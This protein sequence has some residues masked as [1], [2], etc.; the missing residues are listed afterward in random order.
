[1]CDLVIKS[2]CVALGIPWAASC[3]NSS[4]SIPV[5][6]SFGRWLSPAVVAM[7]ARPRAFLASRDFFSRLASAFAPTTGS[8]RS[9]LS[10][11]RGVA[12][13][14]LRAG[15]TPLTTWPHTHPF[16]YTAAEDTLRQSLCIAAWRIDVETGLEWHGGS[17]V[18]NPLQAGVCVA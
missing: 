14:Q 15:A 16:A 6:L 5:L 8:G 9:M 11:S 17:S 12:P 4:S 18:R 1:M 13:M 2:T 7:I 3:A 10:V